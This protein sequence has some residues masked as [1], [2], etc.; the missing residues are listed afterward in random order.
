[1]VSQENYALGIRAQK[2]KRQVSQIWG[3]LLKQIKILQYTQKK[4][5]RKITKKKVLKKD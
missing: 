2:G 5:K 1:M 3:R 4:I